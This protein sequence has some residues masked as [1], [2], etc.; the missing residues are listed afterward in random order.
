M[1]KFIANWFSKDNLGKIFG[2]QAAGSPLTVG[3]SKLLY[4]SILNSEFLLGE[5]IFILLL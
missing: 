5:I 4:G 3:L 1:T 2:F